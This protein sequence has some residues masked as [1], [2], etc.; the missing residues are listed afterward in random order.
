MPRSLDAHSLSSVRQHL[1]A[2][3]GADLVKTVGP[4][5]HHV[6]TTCQQSFG[7]PVDAGIEDRVVAHEYKRAALDRHNRRA[8]RARMALIEQ[9][10]EQVVEL[11]HE[12]LIGKPVVHN[13]FV[14]RSV[15]YLFGATFISREV[16]QF[17]Q[18]GQISLQRQEMPMRLK[19]SC[20]SPLVQK[21]K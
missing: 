10:L 13:D 17:A 11:A 20:I 15:G 2:W 8:N 3:S 19:N 7:H 21:L 4:K 18:I 14:E 1:D 12:G 9:T 6:K 5:F 16:E